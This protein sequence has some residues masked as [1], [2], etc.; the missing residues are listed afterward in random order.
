MDNLIAERVNAMKFVQES[1]L[2]ELRYRRDCKE[3][4]NRLGTFYKEVKTSSPKVFASACPLVGCRGFVVDNKCGKCRN[5]VCE[6]CEKIVYDKHVCKEDDRLS[7]DYTRSQIRSCPICNANIVKDGLGCSQM[8]CTRCQ[9]PFDWES[10][11]AITKDFF[12]NPVYEEWLKSNKDHKD[13]FDVANQ[14]GV[15]GNDDENHVSI[16]DLESRGL[17]RFAKWIR[18]S[19]N[20][21][22]ACRRMH[23]HAN[24]NLKRQFIGYASGDCDDHILEKALFKREVDKEKF[25]KIIAI[26][27]NFATQVHEILI[28]GGDNVGPKLDALRQDSN[29]KISQ[30]A[31]NFR[32]RIK[33][34]SIT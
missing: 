8:F 2:D 22:M 27:V 28:N 6:S 32:A 30:L 5:C 25:S 19:H 13:V 11:K 16:A 3:S 10:G 20:A 21:T 15:K 1:I 14:I 29:R 31:K 26:Y 9:T 7:V 34:I 23:E 33:H 12:H 4:A 24:K 17:G 18:A